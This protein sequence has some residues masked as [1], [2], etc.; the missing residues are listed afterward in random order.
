MVIQVLLTLSSWS[1]E[2]LEPF[3]A[4]GT[5]HERKVR[6]ARYLLMVGA[7]LPRRLDQPNQ[8]KGW[9][10]GDATAYLGRMEDTHALPRHRR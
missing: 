10:Q 8:R 9:V 2:L 7:G 5:A 6:R 3:P 1:Q 4:W